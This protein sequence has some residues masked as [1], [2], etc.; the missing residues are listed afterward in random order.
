VHVRT[1]F[2]NPFILLLSQIFATESIRST[3]VH[4]CVRLNMFVWMCVC[5]CVCICM[6]MCVTPAKFC[7]KFWG[8]LWNKF[9]PC[10]MTCVSLFCVW[11]CIVFYH[12]LVSEYELS[13][14]IRRE[15]EWRVPLGGFKILVSF[16]F[17][18]ILYVPQGGLW[19]TGTSCVCPCFCWLFPLVKTGLPSQCWSIV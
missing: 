12:T 18:H 13:V 16:F 7:L 9:D 1:T 10:T 6:L 15:R 14:L 11:M 5:M 17:C 4:V 3:S 8:L 19:M 2:F